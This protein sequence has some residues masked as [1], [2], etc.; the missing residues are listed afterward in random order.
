MTFLK[1]F[2]EL[3]LHSKIIF[4]I[5]KGPHNTGQVNLKAWLGTSSLPSPPH[6]TLDYLYLTLTHHTTAW[7]GLVFFVSYQSCGN[8]STRYCHLSALEVARAQMVPV[9][10]APLDHGTYLAISTQ[11]GYPYPLPSDTLS[12]PRPVMPP[13]IQQGPNNSP[14]SSP[15]V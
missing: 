10:R 11:S 9:G 14:L 7:Q 4:W 15:P 1:F 5:M 12:R 8:S 13:V 2:C 6:C 3:T